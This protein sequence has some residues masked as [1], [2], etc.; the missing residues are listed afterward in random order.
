MVQAR[1]LFGMEIISLVTLNKE[2][3]RAKESAGRKNEYL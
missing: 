2:K 1:L 3:R